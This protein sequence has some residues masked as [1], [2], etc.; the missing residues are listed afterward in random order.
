MLHPEVGAWLR[1]D[2]A[3]YISG[4]NLYLCLNGS[5][6][7]HIDPSGSQ[8][9]E[10]PLPASG[11][12]TPPS[13]TSGF[14]TL[15]QPWDIGPIGNSPSPAGNYQPMPVSIPEPPGQPPTYNPPP[16]P[17]PKGCRDPNPCQDYIDSFHKRQDEIGNF[18]DARHKAVGHRSK[19]SCSDWINYYNLALGL[20]DQRHLSDECHKYFEISTDHDGAVTQIDNYIQNVYDAMIAKCDK[21]PP[22]PVMVDR[23][24]HPLS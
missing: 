12:M 24:G 17:P 1:R 19:W 16:N 15:G 10:A 6:V 8:L 22:L 18:V 11:T 21:N 2:P 4:T 14:S 9:L 3:T 13:P 20:W 5:P 7:D 23:W